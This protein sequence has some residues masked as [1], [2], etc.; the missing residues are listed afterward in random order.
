M[1]DFDIDSDLKQEK[2][3]SLKLVQGDR[4]NKIK[5]NV[6]EDGQPVNLAGCSVTAKYKRADGEII[7]D[8]VIENI[9]DNSFDAVMDSSIT[10]VA[11]TLK[12]LFTIEKDDVKV[13]TFLLLADVR[14]SIGENTGSS[15]GNT[16]GGSGEVTIDLSNY[17][18]KI[19]T[20]SKNQIDAR[21]KD[22]ANKQLD[23]EKKF[24]LLLKKLGFTE[25]EL[26]EKI[27]DLPRLNLIGSMEG[28]TKDVSCTFSAE[29]LNTYGESIFDNKK[30]EIT[31]QGSSSTK[32]PKKN[33]SIN[34]LENDGVTS[35][36]C[37]LFED[38]A[39]NDGYH[40][41][42][43]YMDS[44]TFARNLACVKIA[45]SGYKNPLEY[46]CC[47]DG[48]PIEIYLNNEYYGLYNWNLKQHAKTVYGLDKSNLNHLM[49]R[50]GGNDAGNIN[51]AQPCNFRALSSDNSEDVA[52]DWED[53]L[54]KTN[55]A[56][57]REKL[58][59][60]IAFVKD[61]D[62]NTFTNNIDSYFNKEYL[63]DYY[64]YAYALNM[65]D[66]LANNLNLHTYDGNIWYVTFYDCDSTMG[67]S[68]GMIINNSYTITP[69]WRLPED[70]GSK[71]SL[72][73][74][75]VSRC[76][77]E[78]IKTR[79]AELRK[80]TLKYDN[81]IA[82]VENCVNKIPNDC[83]V[84][85]KSKWT[86]VDMNHGLDY[87]KT[88]MISRLA[89]VDKQILE[90]EDATKVSGIQLDI[91]KTNIAMNETVTLTAT[92]LP[93][94]ATNK[95]VTW[96]SSNPSVATLTNDGLTAIVTGINEGDC[97]I[98]VTTEDG[99]YV[100][101]CDLTVVKA[102]YFEF[103]VQSNAYN[104]I[105]GSNDNFI[106]FRFT[107]APAPVY[108]FS[109]NLDDRYNVITDLLPTKSYNEHTVLDKENISAGLKY[110]SYYYYLTLS[111]N[112]LGI[113]SD[114]TDDE[115]KNS[116]KTWLTNNSLT[117]KIKLVDGQYN[118]LNI[119]ELSFEQP[120]WNNKN[121]WTDYEVFITDVTT[122][123]TNVEISKVFSLLKFTHL[124]GTQKSV[125]TPPGE[126]Y[127]LY[128]EDNNYKLEV[129]LLDS[130]MSE[131]NETAFKNSFKQLCTLI[132]PV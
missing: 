102:N 88:F 20:Y 97:K 75:K 35:Y 106:Q 126:Y 60:V 53:K 128:K 98:S 118:L 90:S 37:K 22:I 16:G 71:Y 19:E 54:R 29:L 31:W 17:Y 50:A 73:W 32:N 49:Y 33:F 5:I 105:E 46:R 59:R 8:G 82:T 58:N 79:Y 26:K 74:E 80:T 78:D 14:E 12:M 68:V 103:P 28:M 111:Y 21:F 70:Y 69:E 66:S 96:K 115:K 109:T 61:S 13:S 89:Y 107:I 110:G 86:N 124:T 100:A 113:T 65:V 3:Q 132:Y 34:L 92:I 85:N 63:I 7:N 40:L 95:N 47:V 91:T 81:I 121:N 77:K 27:Y 42:A 119:D 108:A 1:R 41:K 117:L 11:G 51:Y 15:G 114:S 101:E 23:Y 87:I 36:K 130:R 127:A 24:K 43:E 52:E 18:K 30:A 93:S 62:D 25:D 56:E 44:A 2:F 45:K 120:S 99:S 122:Q 64:I 94:I 104:K 39:K 67:I 76:F 6:Y 55:T 10:K 131:I 4:G 38:V 83:F 9:H 116:L 123:F 112:T 48:F 84:R 57:D 125:F 129:A 72:L